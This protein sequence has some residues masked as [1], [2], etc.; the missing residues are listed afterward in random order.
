MAVG[1]HVAD[2]DRG[3][4]LSCELGRVQPCVLLSMNTAVISVSCR[5]NVYMNSS[6]AQSDAQLKASVL[7][8]P[9]AI[10]SVRREQTGLIQ[11]QRF[12]CCLHVGSE[13]RSLLARSIR[14]G[15]RESF[16]H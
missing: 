12:L 11:R 15:L 6:Y 14:I 13:G 7:E 3:H 9:V 10:V 4:S 2:F 16:E 1:A 8:Q 5:P